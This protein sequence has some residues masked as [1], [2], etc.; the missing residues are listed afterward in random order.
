M[1]PQDLLLQLFLYFPIDIIYHN[2]QNKELAIKLLG[3]EN[4]N[5]LLHSAK[6]KSKLIN[7][8]VNFGHN[9]NKFIITIANFGAIDLAVKL[10]DKKVQEFNEA[11][12]TLQVKNFLNFTEIMVKVIENLDE[13]EANKILNY[14]INRGKNLIFLKI[15]QAAAKHG[16]KN[17]LN[18]YDLKADLAIDDEEDDNDIFRKSYINI[19]K[20]TSIAESA[21][22]GGHIDIL[23]SIEDKCEGIDK[24]RIAISA[25][26]CGHSKLM[27]DILDDMEEEYDDRFNC[28][29]NCAEGAVEGGHCNLVY[30]I[31]DKQEQEQEDN[32]IIIIAKKA[33]ECGHR[34]LMFGLLNKCKE[35][36]FINLGGMAMWGEFGKYDEVIDNIDVIRDGV[37]P[38]ELMILPSTNHI[39]LFEEILGKVKRDYFNQT[40]FNN[41]AKVIKN[42]KMILHII[43]NY[44]V[45]NFN[46][47]AKAAVKNDSIKIISKVVGKCDNIENLIPIAVGNNNIDII[48]ILLSK[49]N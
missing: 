37:S 5:L 1:L 7:E 10:A 8:L 13:I 2:L 30:E 40:F 16:Y 33:A 29:V 3:E 47:I 15:V 11:N 18:K 46:E 28:Y 24:F 19:D 39:N 22:E 6:N 38:L 26:K 41:I 20:Y 27:Y 25:A 4:I 12:P 21:V 45:N 17:L 44:G 49:I 48:E 23:N 14:L 35:N 34:D 42:E 36:I 43:E 9:S 31:V 32:G